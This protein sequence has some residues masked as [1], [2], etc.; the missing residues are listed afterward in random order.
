MLYV[1]FLV[2]LLE[3]GHG[4]WSTLPALPSGLFGPSVAAPP[5]GI[6]LSVVYFGGSAAVTTVGLS[7]ANVSAGGGWTTVD[8][9]IVAPPARTLGCGV[10]A[11]SSF[12]VLFGS[13]WGGRVG[14]V[15][16]SDVWAIP[17][18][19]SGVTAGSWMSLSAAG[20]GSGPRAR[21]SAACAARGSS[22]LVVF[23]GAVGL[24]VSTNLNDAWT[25]NITTRMWSSIAAGS[26]SAWPSPTAA[27][28][29]SYVS[30]LDAMFFYGGLQRQASG[31]AVSTSATWLL[32]WRG[33]NSSA[34][35]S[36]WL[37]PAVAGN[38][39]AVAYSGASYVA[40]LPALCIFG[41][42]SLS[43]DGTEQLGNALQCL[44][45][46]SLAPG[47]VGAAQIAGPPPP[48]PLPSPTLAWRQLAALGPGSR[49]AQGLAAVPAV[50]APNGTANATTV[51]L[52]GGS[53]GSAAS[54]SAWACE[55][56]Y[57]LASGAWEEVPASPSGASASF[58]TVL[59][60]L[61]FSTAA[62]MLV[63]TLII[64][65]IRRALAR[66]SQRE[67]HRD[68]IV[69]RAM[70]QRDLE[71]A[72][73]WHARGGVGAPPR[74][75]STAAQRGRGVPPDVIAALD[76]ALHRGKAASGGGVKPAQAT[77]AAS[78]TAPTKSVTTKA[79]VSA[80]GAPLPPVTAQAALP[81]RVSSGTAS[82]RTPSP[83][84][85][86]SKAGGSGGATAASS[87]P[88]AADAAVAAAVAAASP[89][90]AAFEAE[91]QLTCAICL[92]A[93]E[94]GERLRLLPC[95]HRFHAASCV[96]KWLL[97]NNSCPVCKAEVVPQE[98]LSALF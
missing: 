75:H 78:P 8:G 67:R 81:M 94:E 22:S 92:T 12:F 88:G 15:T 50:A 31:A 70:L 2:L 56:P 54:V 83:G 5:P 84:R 49:F 91:T 21:H 97:E 51:F 11:G 79:G 47:S 38:A 34:A 37:A 52:L 40:S 42:E 39:P 18:G 46:T 23:G 26:G 69:A 28:A 74:G 48:V 4:Q 87:P 24:D 30:H 98:V 16:F 45:L 73:S 17:F 7:L 90:P 27:L 68:L 58:F 62:V 85:R 29:A 57:P 96:D 65:V 63:L 53:D 20:P 80:G 64:V 44:D 59:S 19:S 9:G 43:G 76:I 6:D 3:S 71:L 66:I 61:V 32:L 86:A 10:W 89:Q 55:P 36:G 41:G 93:F 14:A 13:A 33:S 1:L 60:F 25:F 95:R 82:V 72:E 35:A 77:T